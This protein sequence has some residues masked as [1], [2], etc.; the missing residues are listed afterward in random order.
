MQSFFLQGPKHKVEI[1]GCCNAVE[2]SA[3]ISEHLKTV[4]VK[5]NSVDTEVLEILKFFGTLNI[6]KLTANTLH[7]FSI[8][9]VFL[10]MWG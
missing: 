9:A 1:R 6:S 7:A 5:C 8:S 10:H 3:A 4:E 2:S